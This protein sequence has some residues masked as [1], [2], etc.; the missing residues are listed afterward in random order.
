MR[1]HRSGFTLAEVAIS[2]A[3]LIVGLTGA[4][5]VFIMGV[6]W[7]N[8]IKVNLTA[9]DAAQTVLEDPAILATVEAPRPPVPANPAPDDDDVRGFLHG[10][11]FVRT[12][13]PAA[14]KVLPDGG[15]QL[16][17]V[18]IVGYHGGDDST[19]RR[20]FECTNLLRVR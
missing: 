5:S 3:V 14:T 8:E 10:Y 1:T 6:S 17:R 18:T 2:I 13:D 20:V 19:G 4:V 16:L 9:F 7:A 15:G 12:F 11:Y